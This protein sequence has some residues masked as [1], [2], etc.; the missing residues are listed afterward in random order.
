MDSGL[1]EQLVTGGSLLK[2]VLGVLVDGGV[3]KAKGTFKASLL[4]STVGCHT[5]V[6][7]DCL[8]VAVG[9]LPVKGSNAGGERLG[10]PN[11]ELDMR[12]T[13]ESYLQLADCVGAAEGL[14]DAL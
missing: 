5:I 2:G 7:I 14:M 10:Q 11:R 13:T 4:L 12:G 8:P 9:Y 1:Q 3:S 6:L